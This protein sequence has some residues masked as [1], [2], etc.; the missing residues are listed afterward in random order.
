MDLCLQAFQVLMRNLDHL[1]DQVA[2]M[3]NFAEVYERHSP[4]AHTD[5]VVDDNDDA[6]F[7]TLW[8]LFF[9]SCSQLQLVVSIYQP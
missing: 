1:W 8:T 9:C 2:I 6:P 7:M 4:L 3:K 5:K